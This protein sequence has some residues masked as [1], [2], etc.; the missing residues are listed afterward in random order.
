[1]WLQ[2]NAVNMLITWSADIISWCYDQYCGTKTKNLIAFKSQISDQYAQKI[3]EMFRNE[4]KLHRNC[5]ITHQQN[6]LRISVDRPSSKYLLRKFFVLLF[7]CS[8][9][10]NNMNKTKALL[11]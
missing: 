6:I 10:R 1:M 3:P 2:K 7:E 5:Q 4:R 9:N 8:K 11:Q